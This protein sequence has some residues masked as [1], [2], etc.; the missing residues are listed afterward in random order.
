MARRV[1]P[2]DHPQDVLSRKFFIPDQPEHLCQPPERKRLLISELEV[3]NGALVLFFLRN[4]GILRQNRPAEQKRKT[5]SCDQKWHPGGRMCQE[6]LLNR[7]SRFGP[8]QSEA[9]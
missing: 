7:Q 8:M 1:K 9:L 3:M 6:P 2:L 4:S 5:L